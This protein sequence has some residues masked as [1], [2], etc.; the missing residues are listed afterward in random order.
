[1]TTAAG[2]LY[3][4]PDFNDFLFLKDGVRYRAEE[5]PFCLSLMCQAYYDDSAGYSDL[6]LCYVDERHMLPLF[7]FVASDVSTF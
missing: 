5:A 4:C 6:D 7:S 1:M 2:L 3:V